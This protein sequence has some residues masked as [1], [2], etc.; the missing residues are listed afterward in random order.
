MEIIVVAIV[1]AIG[2]GF[3]FVKSLTV[4][5][6]GTAQGVK[7]MGQFSKILFRWDNHWMDKKWNILRNTERSFYRRRRQG[8]KIFGGLYFYGLWPFWRIHRY[9]HRWSDVKVTEGG[10]MELHFHEE[11]KKDVMLRP[12]VYA[13][14]LSG[15]E[16]AP[17]ERVPVDVLVLV[18][19]RIFNPYLFL[20]VAPPTPIGDILARIRAEMR[21][22][23]TS[24]TLD[25]LLKI[26]GSSLWQREAKDTILLKG[27]KVIEET[28]EKWGLK[29]ADRG[30]ELADISLSPEYQKAF[31]A[32]RTKEAEALGRAEEI[33]G[34]VISAVAKATGQ[35]ISEVQK[36]FRK[37]P[38]VFY[39]E[40][41]EIVDATISKL[42]IE[43]GLYA[44]VEVPGG[45][46]TVNDITRLIAVWKSR[47]SREEKKEEKEEGEKEKK[48][49]Y[50]ALEAE[51]RKNEEKEREK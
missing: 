22:V 13:F 30:I 40:H 28:M 20:F 44:R 50:P 17:P 5:E 39:Q 34:T 29:L 23:V 21:A 8:I 15:V 2:L 42:A 12:A 26:K 43:K 9:L 24:Q 33:M 38:K 4:V 16:T 11:E 49:S 18:T 1:V 3:C 19:M 37:D 10:K 51:R 36:V 6:E 25:E 46:G 35:E 45:S 32:Q 47:W 31:A 7:K 48:P 14:L 27:A 41:Q